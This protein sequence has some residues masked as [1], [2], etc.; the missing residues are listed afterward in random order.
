MNST[1]EQTVEP[2]LH[3]TAPRTGIPVENQLMVWVYRCLAGLGYV[4]LIGFAAMFI[5]PF[6]YMIS[7]AL[8]PDMEILTFPISLI[9]EQPGLGAFSSLFAGTAMTNWLINSFFVT[10]TVTLLQLFTSSMAGYGFARGN[11]PGKDVIFWLLMSAIMVPFTVT[12]IPSY[13]LIARL[14]WIDTFY[15]LIIPAAT[16]S[17]SSTIRSVARCWTR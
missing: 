8:R 3:P 12:M 6:L 2:V 16:S 9:P 1:H 13:I 15:A 5:V 10:I 4:V 11:F 17:F 7:I 14:H